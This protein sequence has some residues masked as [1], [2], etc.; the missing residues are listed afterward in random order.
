MAGRRLTGKLAVI[1]HA[2]V[3]GSTALVQR[4]EHLTHERIHDSFQRFGNTISRYHGQVREL[5]GDALLAEF[6]RA[7]DAVSAAL[8]F[9]LEQSTY[10]AQL[11]DD[12]RLVVRVGIALGEVLIADDTITGE[13]VVLAQRL[14]QLSDPGGLCITPAIREAMP[15]RLPFELENLGE[16]DL[17]GFDEPMAVYRVALQTGAIVPLPETA[18]GFAIDSARLKVVIAT[19]VL[20]LFLITGYGFMTW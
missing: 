4:N 18:E 10:N 9:Q 16:H 7:S 5:R 13:G 15:K 6:E 11:D 3:V 12:I 14:E 17:K 8:C 1:L 20:A 2:D 19:V